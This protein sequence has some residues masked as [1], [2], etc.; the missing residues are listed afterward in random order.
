M[1]GCDS[2]S[3]SGRDSHRRKKLRTT[4]NHAAIQG[5]NTRSNDYSQT[6]SMY[7]RRRSI[8]CYCSDNRYVGVSENRIGDVEYVYKEMIKRSIRPNMNTFNVFVNGLC[9]GGK[10]N[11]AEDVFEDMKAWGV[12]PNVVTYNTLV[13]GYCKRGGAGK[14]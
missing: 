1:R 14:M 10:L 12:L 3:I 13:D 6:F 8:Q 7:S 9:R 4:L 5:K 11:K 2:I